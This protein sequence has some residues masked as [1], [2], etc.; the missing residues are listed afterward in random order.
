MQ[1]HRVYRVVD[2]NGEGMYRSSTGCSAWRLAGL[3]SEVEYN[4]PT[5]EEDGLMVQN[6]PAF[7]RRKGIAHRGIYD[8]WAELRTHRF[9]FESVHSLR[10]WI[11]GVGWMQALHDVGCVVQVYDVPVHD[12]LFGRCQV[13]F[14]SATAVRVLPDLSLLEIGG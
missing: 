3:I 11:Y 9:G 6:Y 10:R 2:S 12:V 14:D 8:A 7:M 13:T 1:I 4:H 5:P